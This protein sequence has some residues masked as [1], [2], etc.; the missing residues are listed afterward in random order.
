MTRLVR[1]AAGLAVKGVVGP[2]AVMDFDNVGAAG[3]INSTA[4][5]T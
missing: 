1:R 2:I 4:S 5:V 3:A